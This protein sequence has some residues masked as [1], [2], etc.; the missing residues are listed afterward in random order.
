LKE[1]IH[2]M[3]PRDHLASLSMGPVILSCRVDPT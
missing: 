3:F 1:R 2:E